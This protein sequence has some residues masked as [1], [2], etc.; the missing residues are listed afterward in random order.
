MICTHGSDETAVCGSRKD[1]LFQSYI[2]TVGKEQ[3]ALFLM[4]AT[5][6]EHYHLKAEHMIQQS[7]SV[8]SNGPSKVKTFLAA[9]SATKEADFKRLFLFMPTPDACRVIQMC[10]P[11]GKRAIKA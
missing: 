1:L 2:P 5:V 3:M 11:S 7:S 6:S 9:T 4:S 10:P 8:F